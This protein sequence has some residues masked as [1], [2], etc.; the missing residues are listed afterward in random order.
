MANSEQKGGASASAPGTRR[1]AVPI[2]RASGSQDYT[3]GDQEFPAQL[4][5]LADLLQWAW[6]ADKCKVPWKRIRGLNRLST[7][8]RERNS[9][10][11]YTFFALSGVP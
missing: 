1:K 4:S 6:L 10:L 8:V 3:P 11:L 7:W 5:S 2:V 9:S